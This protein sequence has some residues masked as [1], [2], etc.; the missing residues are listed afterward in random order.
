[1][2]PG[3]MNHL[4][5]TSETSF[6]CVWPEIKMSTSRR[7]CVAASA[8]GSPQGTT[9]C[10]WMTPMRKS[11][12]VTTFVS[13]KAAP[14]SKSPP[15]M[16]A[17]GARAFNSSYCSRVAMLPVQMTCCILFGTSMRWNFSGMKPARCGT[18]AS[19]STRASSPK[20]LAM[21][22]PGA[23]KN[24]AGAAALC[25]RALRAA[26][27]KAARRLP[28]PAASRRAAARRA[29][30]GSWHAQRGCVRRRVAS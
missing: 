28:S 23:R 15:T 29:S 17:C 8:R 16:C 9:W 25:P 12:I 24:H 2:L 4:P 27:R 11:P 14:S 19:P 18:C 20:F 3:L 13:G 1:M 5:S 22:A 30:N 6:L 10:P 21:A 26:G 7:R